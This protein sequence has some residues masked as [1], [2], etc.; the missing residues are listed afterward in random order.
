MIRKL[1]LAT[2]AAA[3]VLATSA[4]AF[5]ACKYVYAQTSTGGRYVWVC[6]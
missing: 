3:A 4:P 2:A 5:A 6:A 1:I